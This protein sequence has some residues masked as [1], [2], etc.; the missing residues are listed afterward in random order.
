MPLL[1]RSLDLSDLD[2]RTNVIDTL[3]A[4]AREDTSDGSGSLAD[5]ASSIIK[6]L[7]TNCLPGDLT[8]KVWVCLIGAD[9]C[10]NQ[11]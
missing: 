3:T 1:L 6:F 10:L 4:V 2:I 8:S 5:H 11:P 9:I 7:L